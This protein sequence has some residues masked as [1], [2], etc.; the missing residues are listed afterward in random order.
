[1]TVDRVERASLTDLAYKSVVEAIYD[2]TFAPG[3]PV[4][5]DRLAVALG[6]SVTPVREALFRAASEGLLTRESNKGF[7]VTPLLTTT[8]YHHLFEVRRML[9]L[10]AVNSAR[11]ADPPVKRLADLLMRMRSSGDGPAYQDYAAFSSA[12]REFHVVLV[13]M[14][15]NAFAVEA[16]ANLHHHLHVA[17]LYAG[18]GVV[19]SHEAIEEHAAILHAAQSV[20]REALLKATRSHILLAE[21]RL[22]NLLTDPDS[23]GT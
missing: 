3:R 2:R 21:Q 14:S 7:R 12:D 10:C 4:N 16:W 23:I 13:G 11:L 1:M 5:I 6:V 9:E 20:D 19:D 22:V 15:D 18:R 8:E 17:R